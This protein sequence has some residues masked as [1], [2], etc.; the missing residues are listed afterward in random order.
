MKHLY[1]F[2]EIS[3]GA[4]YGV[5]TY[6]RQLALCLKAEKEITL[7]VVNLHDDVKEFNIEESSEG[8]TIY[9]FPYTQISTIADD[10]RYYRNIWF[11]LSAFIPIN[12]HTDQLF[13]LLNS[14]VQYS[15]IKLIRSNF[16]FGRILF[17][18][19]YQ[20]WRFKENM[21]LFGRIIDQTGIE[22]NFYHDV[23]HIICLSKYTK[24]IL[25]NHYH[26]SEDKI[27]VIYN[28]IKDEAIF[29]SNEE[30]KSVKTR[31]F[32]SEQSRLVL[33]VGR[34]DETKGVG[35]LIDAFGLLLKEF[36]DSHLII[37]GNGDI[38]YYLKKCKDI[39]HKV[40]FTGRL[41]KDELYPFYQIADVGVMPSK[42]E[43]CSYVA[44]E[45][46]MFGLPM[47]A[48][49]STGLS[50]MFSGENLKYKVK[51]KEKD[52]KMYISPV[53]LKNKIIEALSDEGY[54]KRLRKQFEDVYDLEIMKKYYLNLFRNVI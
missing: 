5:G 35:V 19:H 45:M 43:Q 36:P 39:W 25:L 1:V 38:D 16:P 11:I 12:N 18:L 50:E 30:K 9:H 54:G 37:I 3:Q 4:L 8:Y 42:N 15:L 44:I 6:I 10:D 33:F 49:A 24:K 17:T 22:R 32:F 51:V 26:V 21:S 53:S 23:N 47:V 20:E 40:T 46:M 2:N 48:S 41:N 7:N 13:F 28:G 14:L 52:E 31:L 27:S 34:L 29:L